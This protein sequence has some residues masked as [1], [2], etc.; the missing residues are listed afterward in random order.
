MEW[1]KKHA[2]TLIILAG[3]LSATIWMNNGLGNIE[4]EVAGLK[5]DMAIM[6]TVLVMKDIMPKELA[7][8]KVD[9]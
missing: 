1:L 2:D 7:V 8:A 3:V 4:K 9:K 6:K 5:T